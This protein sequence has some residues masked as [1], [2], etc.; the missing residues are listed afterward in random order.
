MSSASTSIKRQRF[1]TEPDLA[2]DIDGEQVMVNSFVLMVASPVFRQMLQT[3]MEEHHT[4]EIKLPGKSRSEFAVFVD[5]LQLATMKP[6]TNESAV[7]LS[8]WA[9]EYDVAALTEMCENHMIAHMPVDANT[10]EECFGHAMQHNLPRRAS[11]CIAVAKKELPQFMNID[12]IRALI[13]SDSN[14]FKEVWPEICKAAG[15]AHTMGLQDPPAQ[16]I[17]ESMWPFVCTAIR[18]KTLVAKV[19]DL[20]ETLY[21]LMGNGRSA[22][23]DMM[24]NLVRHDK[25]WKDCLRM[26]D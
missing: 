14:L 25:G 17:I 8:V 18:H 15:L 6:L 26:L 5:S 20:P 12:R 23:R 9:N 22:A 24:E 13:V 1:S 7:F 3:P 21:R 4:G 10:F 19:Y 2:V 11:Q 16:E